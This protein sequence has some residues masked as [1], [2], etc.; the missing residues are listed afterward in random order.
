MDADIIESNALD[1]ASMQTDFDNIT[2]QSAKSMDQSDNVQVI[3]SPD[4]SLDNSSERTLV[5]NST[6]L[7]KSRSSENLALSRPK[8][9]LTR[10]NYNQLNKEGFEEKNFLTVGVEETAPVS[11]EEAL[12]RKDKDLWVK[13]FDEEMSSLITNDVF[14]ICHRPSGTNIV[15]YR[16]VLTYKVKPDGGVMPKARLVAKGYSQQYGIDYVSTFSPVVDIDNVRLIFSVIANEKLEIMQFDIKT[17]FLNGN[18]DEVIFMEEPE[19]YKTNENSVWKLKKSLYGLKQSPR[20]WN[21]KFTEELERL[22]FV[23]LEVDNC[24]L[25]KHS[26]MIIIAI[27]VD[28]A[29]ICAKDARHCHQVI[30]QLRKRFDIHV[31]KNNRFLGFQYKQFNDGSIAIHQSHYIQKILARFGMSDCKPVPTPF[32]CGQMV[33]VDDTI[34]S[35]LEF[36]EAVGALQYAAGQ[37]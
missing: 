13:A 21:E 20:K 1:N 3:N 14:E 10:L 27:Y 22:N 29:I 34:E 16:W 37:T 30:H 26:P 35:N 5:K 31:M 12:K 4:V 15:G 18:L 8:R 36:R 11:Y 32:D 33:K 28:D 9:S 17:A 7:K 23:Q 19:G 2:F 6:P 25:I 24:I